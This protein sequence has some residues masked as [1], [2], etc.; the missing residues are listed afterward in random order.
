[1]LLGDWKAEPPTP[2]Q[3]RAVIPNL[4]GLFNKLQ[5]HSLH[6][7]TAQTSLEHQKLKGKTLQILRLL[8]GFN[9]CCCLTELGVGVTSPGYWW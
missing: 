6:S 3:S 5:L 9:C 1:M 4:W 8:S 7:C 2:L